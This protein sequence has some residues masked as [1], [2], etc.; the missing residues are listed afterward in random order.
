MRKRFFPICPSSYLFC[1][2][3][4]KE[5]F[6]GNKKKKTCCSPKPLAPHRTVLDALC[7]F[8]FFF[9]PTKRSLFPFLTL[10]LFKGL[11]FSQKKTSTIEFL[12]FRRKQRRAHLNYSTAARTF[13]PYSIRLSPLAFCLFCLI[14]RTISKKNKEKNK[15]TKQ[16]QNKN[17]TFFLYFL[18]FTLK[19]LFFLLFEYVFFFGFC[20]IFFLSFFLFCWYSQKSTNNQHPTKRE[21]QHSLPG[22]LFFVYSFFLI[23][24]NHF[25]FET[26]R[27][28]EKAPA[29]TRFSALSPERHIFV[30]SPLSVYSPHHTKI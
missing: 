18:L 10:Y 29:S 30:Y 14:F 28:R 4:F 2:L 8:V 25:L 7:L 13:S 24:F 23:I 6:S 5:S 20:F 1:P 16:K 15:K 19:T 22:S 17:T 21:L 3:F 11:S 9:L 27:C 12:L 26:V